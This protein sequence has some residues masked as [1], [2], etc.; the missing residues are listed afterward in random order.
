MR[1]LRCIHSARLTGGGPIEGIRQTSLILRELGHDVELLSMDRPGTVDVKDFDFPVHTVGGKGEG[2]GYSAHADGWLLKNRDRFDT[3]VVSGLWQYH[4]FA[5]W[6]RCR[7]KPGYFVF[8]HGMLDPWF[9]RQYPLKHLKKWLYWLMAEYRVLR[10]ARAVLFTCEEERRLARESFWLYR[11]REKVVNYGTA[12][13]E[14]DPQVQAGLFWQKFPE[15]RQKKCI[16]FLSR[17][18]PKKGCDLLIKA[19]A[20]TK[21]SED[22]H[23][24]MAGPDQIGWTRELKELAVSLGINGRITWTGM[25]EGEMKWA[26]FRACELFVLPSHQENFGI[27]VAEALACGKPVLITKAVNIWREVEV[28]GGGLVAEDTEPSLREKLDTWFRMG[29]NERLKMSDNALE[30]FTRRFEV[31]AAAKHLVAVISDV[32]AQDA[33]G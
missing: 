19:L 12:A 16:L 27:V 29:A 23:L 13:P 26:A 30:S 7:V 18:H 28:D 6:K 9:K 17:I 33:K 20:K 3:V 21:A 32:M 14:G 11:C 10:D 2:Y 22:W 24:V 5:V 4:G 25:L 8:P 1:I 15:T 31:R